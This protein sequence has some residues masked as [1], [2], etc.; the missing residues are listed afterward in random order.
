MLTGSSK[1][2]SYINAAVIATVILCILP[3][4]L[5]CIYVHPHYDDYYLVNE[6][7]GRNIFE[8]TIYWYNNWTG[9]FSA[10][11]IDSILAHGT[12]HIFIYRIY[13]LVIIFLWLFTFTAFF[14]TLLSKIGVNLKKAFLFSLCFFVLFLYKIPEVTTALYYATCAYTCSLGTIATINLLTI[15]LALRDKKGIKKFLFLIIG[16]ILSIFIG[17]S[18]EPVL[19]MGSGFLS[20]A[21][22]VLLFKKNKNAPHL[23]LFIALI[24][25]SGMLM[26]LAPGNKVRGGTHLLNIT[27]PHLINSLTHSGVFAFNLIIN[28]LQNPVLL[29]STFLFVPIAYNISEKD[30]S[31]RD[32]LDI[33]P[34]LSLLAIFVIATVG[35]F[36]LV[37]TEGLVLPRVTN[38]IYLFIYVQW[39][40]FIQT[41]LIYL[42]K[43]NV[44][45]NLSD[46]LLYSIKVMLVICL[47]PS[48][49]NKTVGRAYSDLLTKAPEYSRQ[50]NK[51]YAT[52]ENLKK[53]GKSNI[54]VSP[55]FH[56]SRKYPL[57]IYYNYQ[58]LTKDPS[59]LTNKIYANYWKVDSIT[60]EDTTPMDFLNKSRIN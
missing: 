36:P 2:K 34:L 25:I 31:L 30:S 20:M 41:L 51:R 12:T 32:L 33:N 43:K 55:L 11:F 1:I 39:F 8:A 21:F 48:L 44:V 40:I 18:Y 10:I 28:T 47:I 7:A 46:N 38:Q 56:D 53:E 52:I 42:S 13:P 3:F 35:F 22:L 49:T 37:W 4:I 24:I 15:L 26:I 27:A 14:Y 17:G 59:N 45:F 19:L 5:I 57:T 29:L 6:L 54:V 50:L 16:S 60:I 58:E 23:L 9:R